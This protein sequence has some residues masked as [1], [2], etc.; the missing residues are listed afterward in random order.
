M[1]L[2]RNYQYILNVE[3]NTDSIM[4]MEI[5]IIQLVVKQVVIRSELMKEIT[6]R[7]I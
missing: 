2:V 5:D 4:F 3:N 1:L 7:R 6:D